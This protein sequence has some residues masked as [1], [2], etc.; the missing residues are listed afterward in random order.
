M[1]K[2]ITTTKR[3]REKLKQEKRLEKQKRKELRRSN[4]TSSFEDMIAYVDENGMLHSTPQETEKKEVELSDIEVS[5]PKQQ[6]VEVE[7]FTG[8][9]EYFD[10]AKGF[11][12]IKDSK[13]VEK[14]FFHISNAPANIAEGDKVTF[15]KERGKRGMNAVHISIINK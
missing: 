4:G 7:P 6:E 11:G 8:S 13:T 10:S 14:F 2:Q 5:V 1:V 15:E 12:F 9:V 3:E